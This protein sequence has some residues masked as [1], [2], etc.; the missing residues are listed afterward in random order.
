MLKNKFIRSIDKL[1][2]TIS[3]NAKNHNLRS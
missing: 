2:T 1:I 3:N